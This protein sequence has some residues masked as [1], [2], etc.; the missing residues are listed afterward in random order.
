[1]R[2]Q[3]SVVTGTVLDSRITLTLS[4]LCH[5]G[6]ASVELVIDMVEEGIVDPTGRDP[7]EWRFTGEAVQRVQIV[8]RL[9]E[10]LRVNL[11]GAALALELMDELDALR[12]QSVKYRTDKQTERHGELR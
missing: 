10:D 9:T 11:P 4:E 6:G 1:M 2:K 7:Q 8:R 3:I 12:Q 5:M